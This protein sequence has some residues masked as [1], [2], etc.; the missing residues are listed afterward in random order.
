[1]SLLDNASVMNIRANPD[2]LKTIWNTV[3]PDLA[4]VEGYLVTC[5]S[6]T[7]DPIRILGHWRFNIHS[8]VSAL[9]RAKPN[10]TSTEMQKA[11][12]LLEAVFG[13]TRIVARPDKQI[14]LRDAPPLKAGAMAGASTGGQTVQGQ[15]DGAEG[16]YMVNLAGQNLPASVEGDRLTLKVEGTDWVFDRED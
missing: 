14:S 5:R 4:D 12:K 1:M 15:W 16:S 6:A 13:N 9:R 8:A 11:R 10:L 3:Q 7:Y 2:L